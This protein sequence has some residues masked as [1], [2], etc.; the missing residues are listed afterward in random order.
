MK[1]ILLA[2]TILVGFAGVASAEVAL[3]G[4]ARMG[5]LGDYGDDTVFTSRARVQ[6]TMSGESDGGLSFGASFRADNAGTGVTL[7]DNQGRSPGDDGYNPAT[8]QLVADGGAVNGKAGSVFVS[9]AFGTLSMGDVDG[10]AESA[11]GNVDGVGL[12]GLGDYNET[13]YISDFRNTPAVLYNYSA[14][15]L[16]FYLSAG[17]VSGTQD[18]YGLGVGYATDTWSV[19]LGYEN[20]SGDVAADHVIIGGSATF[21]GVTMKAIYGQASGR[22]A[23]GD[24]WGLSATYAWDALSATVY[25]YDDSDISNPDTGDSLGGTEAYGLGASYDLGGGLS[26]VGGY[27]QDQTIDDSAFDLGLSMAF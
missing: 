14:D 17:Q 7:Q 1:K 10:A 24:Q 23:D 12:T 15:A 9:G 16:S 20:A 19:G 5:I 18:N 2:S 13:T 3:S 21:G 22:D 26:V 27:V 8:A 25:Y 4:D 11:V 6:F